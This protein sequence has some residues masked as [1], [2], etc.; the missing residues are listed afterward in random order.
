MKV[1]AQINDNMVLCEVSQAEIARL[2][3]CTSRYDK[4][5]NNNWT[6]VGSE[7]NLVEAFKALDTLRS[8]DGAQLRYMEQRIKGMNEAFDLVK[9]SYEKLTLL[10]T[11]KEAGTEP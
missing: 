6:H 1:I 10:D 11:L 7:H 5:W 9:E 4:E 2:H 8:F 3:G